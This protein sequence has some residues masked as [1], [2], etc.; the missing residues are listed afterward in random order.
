MQLLEIPATHVQFSM[1][2]LGEPSDGTLG[3]LGQGLLGDSANSENRPLRDPP[4]L[5]ATEVLTEST[6]ALYP[7][8]GL[9]RGGGV[10]D[11][12]MFG[13]PRFCEQE[14]SW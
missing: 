6:E 12:V 11:A 7:A 9:V 14:N 10:F 13:T 8:P 1:S 2:P 5:A 3:M 4:E